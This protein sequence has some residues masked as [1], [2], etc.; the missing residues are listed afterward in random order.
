MTKSLHVIIN[1]S[2]CWKFHRIYGYQPS[3][4][5]FFNTFFT[6]Y[7]IAK[8]LILT[9]LIPKQNKT[10]SYTLLVINMSITKYL[11]I[12]NIYLFSWKYFKNKLGVDRI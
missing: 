2:D 5:N 12:H 3:D 7:C 8:V 11:F 4:C 6:A 1:T 10:Y 9:F